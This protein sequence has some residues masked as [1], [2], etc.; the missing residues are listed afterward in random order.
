MMMRS[1]AALFAPRLEVRPP[2]EPDR[3]QFVELFCDDA[4]ML[5]SARD[6]EE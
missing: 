2:R 1:D 4:F 3:G 5:L 6:L